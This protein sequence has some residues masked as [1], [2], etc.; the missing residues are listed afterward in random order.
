MGDVHVSVEW[1]CLTSTWL[2]QGFACLLY[3]VRKTESE[4][5][6]WGIPAA[7]GLENAVRSVG[8][9]SMPWMSQTYLKLPSD[10]AGVLQEGTGKL[11]CQSPFPRGTGLVQKNG[12]G[13]SFSV[14][15][16]IVWPLHTVMPGLPPLDPSL[17]VLHSLQTQADITTLVINVS[18]T[19]SNNPHILIKE[20][21]CSCAMPK[22]QTLGMNV[23]WSTILTSRAV[24]TRMLATGT[25]EPCICLSDSVCA[26]A[27][28]LIWPQYELYSLT[29]WAEELR[30]IFKQ[31]RMP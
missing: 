10:F 7:R 29:H 22:A 31:C 11:P 30:G 8:T 16:R 20:N 18:F 27:G 26:V 6:F 25:Q 13:I 14:C 3:F 17:Y 2:F 24:Q 21:E 12:G 19:S 15:R 4:L 23:L 9:I 28:V 5:G 1:L